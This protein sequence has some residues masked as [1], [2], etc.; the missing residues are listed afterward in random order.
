[1]GVV[2][3][4]EC[5]GRDLV[6]RGVFLLCGLSSC[7]GEVIGVI[8]LGGTPTLPGRRWVSWLTWGGAGVHSL[9]MKQELGGCGGGMVREKRCMNK[10]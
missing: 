10:G 8:T 1:M 6:L 3:W 9:E 2:F 7:P 4:T 5:M